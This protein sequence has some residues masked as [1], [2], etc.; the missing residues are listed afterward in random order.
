MVKELSAIYDSNIWLQ[1]LDK[2][3]ASLPELSELEGKSVLVTG[4]NGLICSAVID[5]LMRYNESTKSGNT[6]RVTAAGLSAM[7]MS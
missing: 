6:I 4:A 7:V 5:V 3:I 1:D 2:I